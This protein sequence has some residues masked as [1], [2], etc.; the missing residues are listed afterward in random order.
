VSVALRTG[1]LKID[2]VVT[3]E[4]F[5]DSCKVLILPLHNAEYKTFMP[6]PEFI[7]FMLKTSYIILTGTEKVKDSSLPGSYAGMT[8]K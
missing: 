4:H 2:N 6:I 5:S 3:T 7:A 1:W 8:C